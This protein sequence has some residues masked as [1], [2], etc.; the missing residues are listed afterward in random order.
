MP[1]LCLLPMW[2]S[3]FV[4]GERAG[5]SIFVCMWSLH[6]CLCHSAY[7]CIQVQRESLTPGSL[8]ASPVRVC[9][10]HGRRYIRSGGRSPLCAQQGMCLYACL[11]F[12]EVSVRHTVMVGE[13]GLA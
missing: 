10:A 3:I 5:R 9:C 8:Y 12:A 13:K 11:L 4:Q 2:L 6:P 7:A 1:C